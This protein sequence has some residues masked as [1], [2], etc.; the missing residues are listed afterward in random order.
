MNQSEPILRDN[1][2]RFVIFP[3]KHQ[4]IWDR[5]RGLEA[6]SWTP[7]EI[8]LK[9]NAEIHFSKEN[10]EFLENTLTCFAAVNR[11]LNGIFTSSFLAEI[12]YPEAK[13]FYGLQN[14]KEN[15]HL[16]TYGL[17]LQNLR[18]EALERK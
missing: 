10:K 18:Q 17:L 11:N 15:T 7:G 6:I 4:D 5:Y 3:N 1:K 9:E 12:Q 14:V 16:Q 2:D 13:F 8:G